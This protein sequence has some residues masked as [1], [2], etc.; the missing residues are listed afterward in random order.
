MGALKGQVLKIILYLKYKQ[1][2]VS[3]NPY[4]CIY[5]IY[6]CICVRYYMFVYEYYRI[7]FYICNIC[8]LTNM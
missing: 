3:I 5:V 7:C 8:N 4:L 6:D 1:L 2:T